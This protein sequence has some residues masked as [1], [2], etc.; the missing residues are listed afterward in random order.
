MEVLQA[1]LAIDPAQRPAY[2]E[3]Q[4]MLDEYW[5]QQGQ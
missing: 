4:Q 2:H 3:I 1:M 5:G